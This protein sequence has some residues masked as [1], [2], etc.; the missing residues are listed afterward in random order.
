MQGCTTLAHKQ[1]YQQT[2]QCLNGSTSGSVCADNIA[3]INKIT[4][5]SSENHEFEL[6]RLD[7]ALTQINSHCAVLQL[8][9]FLASPGTSYQ[10]HDKS[11]KLFKKFITLPKISEEDKQFTLAILPMLEQTN[12]LLATINIIDHEIKK[13]QFK[14]HTVEYVK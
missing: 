2:P 12:H 8:A 14:N 9:I 10:N 4:N 13:L 3:Y 6:N 5:S 7:Q 11:I 1:P